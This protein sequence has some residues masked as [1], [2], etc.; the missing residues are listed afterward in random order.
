MV[1]VSQISGNYALKGNNHAEIHEAKAVEQLAPSLSFLSV[2]IRTTI[3]GAI[4]L[5]IGRKD[6]AVSNDWRAAHGTTQHQRGRDRLH[7]GV[8]RLHFVGKSLKGL[9][10]SCLVSEWRRREKEETAKITVN[11]HLCRQLVS[12]AGCPRSGKFVPVEQRLLFWKCEAS[13]MEVQRQLIDERPDAANV[14]PSSS[15]GSP[16]WF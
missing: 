8:F 14:D 12:D 15:N 9:R 2:Q 3:N 1:S 6:K 11:Q 10:R 7:V 5:V 4:P 16:G 13:P